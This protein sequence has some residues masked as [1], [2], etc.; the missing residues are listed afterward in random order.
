[1]SCPQDTYSY[2]APTTYIKFDSF[3][4]E[5]DPNA[6]SWFD[7]LVDAENIPPEPNKDNTKNT[8][9]RKSGTLQSNVTPTKNSDENHNA[10]DDAM[11]QQPLNIISSMDAWRATNKNQSGHRVSTGNRSSKRL[12]GKERN[13]QLAKIRAERR[14]VSSSVHPDDHPPTKKQKLTYRSS[15]N[16]PVPQT[17]RRTLS[18]SVTSDTSLNKGLSTS[19]DKA[20]NL[21]SPKPKSKLLTMPSTP[22]VLKRKNLPLKPKSSEEQ[23]LEVMQQLQK[24]VVEQR[25]KNEETLKMAIA[26]AGQ[27]GKRTIAPVTK[28]VD[29]HFCTD[30]RLKK[31]PEEQAGDQ[32]KEV[33]FAAAL[34]KHPPSP[35]R[36]PKGGHTVPKPFNL[37]QGNKRKLEE[38]DSGKYVSTAEQVLAFCKKTPTRYHLRS[39]QKDMEG[40]SPVKA[41]KQKLTNPK[42]PLLVTKQRYRPATC[43]SSAEMETEELDKLQQF[44]FK[45]QELDPRI[46]EGVH[47]FPKKPPVKEPTKAIGFDLEIEKRI[48]QREKKEEDEEETYSFHSRPCPTKILEDVVGVPEKKTLPVTVPKSPAFAL[49]NRVR[50]QEEEEE[51]EEVPVIKANPMP[52]YGVPF[53]PKLPEQRQV[54]VNPFSF[55]DRDRAKQLQKEK[56]LD[57]LRKEEVPKFKAQ[58]LPQFDYISLPEKKIKM[59]TQQEPFQLEIDKRG[60]SKIQRWKQQM[61]EE[62]KQQKEMATFKARPNTVTHQEPFVPKKENRSLTVQEGFELATERRAKERQEFERRLAETE[63]QKQLLEEE[64]RRR[65]EEQE[66]EE[67]NRLR[68]ELVHKAQPIRK[69]RSVEVKASDVPLTIP[70][71]PKFSDRFKC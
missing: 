50:V 12:S 51:E 46:L 1:M 37:S 67:I 53:K 56:K 32:Y 23:E 28:P 35:V 47:I 49:K 8:P 6:D 11:S 70:K 29:F 52:H 44:K 31:H 71:S 65:Q 27:P 43:K 33:D 55:C 10:Q 34:R 24:E 58:P 14:T 20:N 2:D 69:F 42:T 41:F 21:C 66:K 26:G 68:H 64:E 15:E 30:D 59:P 19:R 40:P 45:A 39:R 5:D 13:K 25:K 36:V 18:R 16:K 38:S 48:K 9:I 62:L 22:T 54:E 4:G 63:T 3:Q 7:Q 60:S 61:Q 17:V 57:D